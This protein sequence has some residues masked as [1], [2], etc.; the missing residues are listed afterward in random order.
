MAQNNVFQQEQCNHELI[1]AMVAY[2]RPAQDQ[3]NKPS[4]MKE[5]RLLG[6]N[7]R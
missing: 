2:I 5:R 6:P 3:A 4:S 7:P 1:A